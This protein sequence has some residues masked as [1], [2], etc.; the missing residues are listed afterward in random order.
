MQLSLAETDTCLSSYELLPLLLLLP[1]PN[2]IIINNCFSLTKQFLCSHSLY[3]GEVHK[4]ELF[5]IIKAGLDAL[6]VA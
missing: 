2:A 6:P 4:S 3:R 1:Q 5:G